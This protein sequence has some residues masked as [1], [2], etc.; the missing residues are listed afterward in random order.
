LAVPVVILEGLGKGVVDLLFIG[1][2][3]AGEI[4]GSNLEAVEVDRDGKVDVGRGSG[5]LA[6][7][8]EHDVCVCESE[9]DEEEGGWARET[10]GETTSA[11]VPHFRGR[12]PRSWG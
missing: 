1:V 10:E 11:S 4:G 6:D 8:L 7:L 12:P 3:V 5:H 9:E 2:D